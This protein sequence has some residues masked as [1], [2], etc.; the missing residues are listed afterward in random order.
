[1]TIDEYQQQALKTVLPS[2]NNIPYVALGLSSEAGEV[3]SKI[4][5]WIRDNNSDPAKLDKESLVAELGDALWYIAVMADMLGFKLDEVA[6]K[7][8]DKLSDRQKRDVL[9]GS[10]DSR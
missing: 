3:A 7:N 4:K 2:S 1:M 5:K 6:Q 9:T 8:A 10:G